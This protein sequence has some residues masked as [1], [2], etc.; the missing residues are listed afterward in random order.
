MTLADEP[1]AS[2]IETTAAPS[3]PTAPAQPAQRERSRDRRQRRL[4]SLAERASGNALDGLSS[5]EVA[6]Q[7]KPYSRSHTRRENRKKREAA[8]VEGLNAVDEALEDIANALAPA[9][10][11]PTTIAEASTRKSRKRRKGEAAAAAPAASSVTAK[12]TEA[13]RR[14]ALC[15]SARWALD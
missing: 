5:A 15:A 2:E 10:A 8:V 1:A 3:E 4:D 12:A 7:S 11:A 14:K 13:R 9:A 6:A